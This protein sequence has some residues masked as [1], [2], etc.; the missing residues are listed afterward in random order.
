MAYLF[1]LVFASF[2]SPCGP[3]GRTLTALV[4]SADTN[5]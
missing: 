5:S 3:D 4:P 2:A 1:T